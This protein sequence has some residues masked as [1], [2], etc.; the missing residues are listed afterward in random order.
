MGIVQHTVNGRALYEAMKEGNGVEHIRGEWF[1]LDDNGKPTAGCALGLM[2]INLGV[3]GRE[4]V[5][6]EA[7]LYSQLVKLPV[8]P[9]DSK[10]SYDPYDSTYQLDSVA[11]AIITWNDANKHVYNP[12]NNREELEYILP[13]FEE[14]HQMVHDVLEPYFDTQFVVDVWEFDLPNF[15]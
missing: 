5:N 2:A 6:T 9:E 15:E 8:V 4:S 10:W 1:L 11:S 7:N 14:V 12:L 3:K 13:T